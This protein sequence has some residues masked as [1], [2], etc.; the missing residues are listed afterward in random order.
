MKQFQYLLLQKQT[1]IIDMMKASEKIM[2]GHIKKNPKV[3][4]SESLTISFEKQIDTAMNTITAELSS[5]IEMIP[6]D[7]LKRS[8][9]EE[10]LK[11]YCVI[12]PYNAK[13]P[14]EL[15]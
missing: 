8:S 1:S 15:R 6:T 2:L 13:N 11:K 3:W 4:N 14:T 10:I 7:A 9:R 5:A 12:T